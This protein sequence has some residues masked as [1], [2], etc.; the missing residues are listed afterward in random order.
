MIRLQTAR[1]DEFGDPKR[2]KM[3]LQV[4]SDAPGKAALFRKVYTQKVSPRHAIK[5]FCLQCCWMD[6]PA[7]RECTA[8]ECPIWDFRP[9]QAGANKALRGAAA[10]EG[11]G[12]AG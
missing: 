5:A 2:A 6:E 9:Y 4:Q 7:I 12:H 10:G 1:P 3:L 11:G 8:P